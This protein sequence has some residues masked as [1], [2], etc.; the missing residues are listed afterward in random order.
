MTL[1]ASWYSGWFVVSFLKIV[2][3]MKLA[4]KSILQ[5]LGF[6]SCLRPEEQ[7]SLST[8]MRHNEETSLLLQ[9]RILRCLAQSRDHQ[10][11]QL[12]MQN[13]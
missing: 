9:R 4:E 8:C 3:S 2:I 12:V 5:I 11:F 10:R 7:G 6:V 1:W 13:L